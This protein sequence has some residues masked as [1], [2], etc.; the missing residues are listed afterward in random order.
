[1]RYGN[2]DR[3]EHASAA[4]YDEV[5]T[6]SLEARVALHAGWLVADATA[7]YSLPERRLT[8]RAN[9]RVENAFR[10]PKN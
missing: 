9:F 10:L 5:M 2:R 7:R 6:S 1:M 4:A 3:T 8:Q